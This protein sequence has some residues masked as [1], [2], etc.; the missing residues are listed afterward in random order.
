MPQRDTGFE[1][2]SP[3]FFGLLLVDHVDAI[4]DVGE[5][6]ILHRKDRG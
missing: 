6:A 1:R 2:E 5:I 4:F 3:V